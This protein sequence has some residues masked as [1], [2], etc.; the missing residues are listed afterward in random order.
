MGERKFFWDGHGTL[1]EAVPYMGG[2]PADTRIKEWKQ[3]AGPIPPHTC[4]KIDLVIEGLRQSIEFSK[5]AG[6][7]VHVDEAN[8]LAEEAL[9]KIAGLE[10]VMEE[11]RAANEKLRDGGEFWYDRAK[12]LILENAQLKAKMEAQKVE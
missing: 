11:I 12:E 6:R 1:Y 4:P 3:G 10:G 9:R 8:N 2:M 5:M 7:S